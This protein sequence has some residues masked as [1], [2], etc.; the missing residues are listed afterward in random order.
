MPGLQQRSQGPRRRPASSVIETLVD[1]AG[2]VDVPVAALECAI[3]A[4][5]HARGATEGEVSVALVDDGFIT[6]LNVDYLSQTGPT[7]VIAF[8]LH[9]DGQPLLGDIY[10][11]YEQADRQARALGVAL[12]EEFVRLVMHGTLHVLGMDHPR[13]AARREGSEMYLLQ[14]RLVK[15]VLSRLD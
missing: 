10:V 3:R 13:A 15:D 4:A 14:E 9:D 8:A 12:R 11:G 7:D 6:R 5:C 1:V 2:R